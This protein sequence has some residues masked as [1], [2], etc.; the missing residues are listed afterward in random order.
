[1]VEAMAT[2]QPIGELW[3]LT[4]EETDV[5]AKTDA[6]VTNF[7]LRYT[8]A[9]IWLY[10]VPVGQELVLLP[11]HRFGCYIEDEGVPAE[12]LD[13]QHVRIEV[14]DATL[15]RMEIPLQ[16]RYVQVKEMQDA[17]KMAHLDILQPLW[18]KAGD[19]IYICGYSPNT[20]YTI[21]VSESFFTLE[22]LRIRPSMYK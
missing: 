9:P 20:V 19:W 10:Q 7:A 8:Y 6:E 16:L 18:L 21:D 17:D 5:T 15:R 1:M 11:E 4:S 2:R 3:R 13:T 14:W 12:W 22:L